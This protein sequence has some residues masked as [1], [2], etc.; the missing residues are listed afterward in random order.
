MPSIQLLFDYSNTRLES[1]QFESTSSKT[2]LPV[3]I[4]IPSVPHIHECAFMENHHRIGDDPW[5]FRVVVFDQELFHHI[6]GIEMILD[7]VYL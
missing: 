7:V 5:L 2:S 1:N 4:N 3:P 6:F